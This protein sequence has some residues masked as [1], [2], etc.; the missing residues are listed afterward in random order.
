MSP[1]PIKQF[2]FLTIGFRPFFLFAGLYAILSMLAWMGWLLVHSMNAIVPEPTIAVAPHLWHGHEML[3][4]FASAVVTGFLLTALPEWTGAQRVAGM[5]LVCL[6]TVWLAG[7]VVVWFSAYLPASIVAVVDMAHL[8]LLAGFVGYG[9][10][11][12]PAP[13]ILIFLALL[14]VQIS[15]NGAIHA[16]WM[17]WTDDTASLGLSIAVL[18]TTLLIVILGGRIVPAF[19]RNVLNRRPDG[20]VLPRSFKWL[21][22]VSIVGVA[23]VLVGLATGLP[24]GITGSLAALAATANAVRL[25]FWRWHSVL[26]NPL[27]WCMHLAYLWIPVGLAMMAAS[28]LGDWFSRNAALHV[29]AVGAI[30]GMTLAM[31][32]RAPLGHTGRALSVGIPISLAYGFIAVAALLRGFALDLF[33]AHYYAIVFA[34]GAFWTA[35]FAIFITVYCPIL[36]GPSQ[37]KPSV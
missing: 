26:D 33:P 9:M 2:P 30:G 21:D 17:A 5:A 24:D 37:K 3:F 16:Q 36:V 27:L 11:S 7:R 22:I 8:I 1:E 25:A 18:N 35:G 12:K 23:A 14:I 13:R 28:L 31:M 20:Q 10:M 6:G 32:T 15:A 4:G 29:L 19:T 34:A